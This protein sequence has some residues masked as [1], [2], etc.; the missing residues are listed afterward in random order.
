MK[1]IIQNVNSYDPDYKEINRNKSE[2]DDNLKKFDLNEHLYNYLSVMSLTQEENENKKENYCLKCKLF[3]RSE[4]S[5]EH[6]D[7]EL[8]NN[9]KDLQN[10]TV[11]NN[12][13]DSLE[14][15]FFNNF[16]DDLN[17]FDKQLK[18]KIEQSIENLVKK[19][20]DLKKSKAN[21]VENLISNHKINFH[22]I[23]KDFFELKY[24]FTHF[25]S[26]NDIFLNL[27]N[28]SGSGLFNGLLKKNKSSNLDSD[29]TKINSSIITQEVNNI[30]N[31]NM[32][33]RNNNFLN[34]S[35]ANLLHNYK[36][37]KPKKINYFENKIV[38]DI[39]YLIN[40]DLNKSIELTEQKLEKFL[41]KEKNNFKSQVDIFENLFEKFTRNINKFQEELKIKPISEIKESDNLSN[42]FPDFAN[43][44]HLR[45]KKYKR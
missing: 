31:L 20:N 4:L 45:L 14:D 6:L 25:Y 10:I 9:D 44:L 24:K 35:N 30:N 21:D 13:F 16:T 39:F 11:L 29:L 18:Q 17:E 3:F 8:I 19:L 27:N 26:K 15:K 43:S 42:I 28:K 22:R 41:D 40:L 36:S 2:I 12:L 7:H 32:S 1:D 5:S 37:I 23:K 38:K 33:S 34:S